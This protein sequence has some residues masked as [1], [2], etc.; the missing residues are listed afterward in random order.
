[1][2]KIAVEKPFDDIKEVLEGKGHQVD[3][4]NSDQELKGYDVG[5]VRV[6]NDGDTGLYDFPIVSVEGAS[7][8]EV[9]AQ[10]ERYIELSK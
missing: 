1:M 8:E 7:I 10:V 5:V 9:V 6:Q 2:A 3:L 4:V